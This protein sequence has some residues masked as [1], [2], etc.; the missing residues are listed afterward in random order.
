[1][2]PRPLYFTTL[3]V[4]RNLHFFMFRM[5]F[6]K[7]TVLCTIM[8]FGSVINNILVH[9]PVEQIIN[10][11]LIMVTELKYNILKVSNQKS[12]ITNFLFEQFRQ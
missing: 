5:Y 7:K 10:I 6:L 1:M 9:N 8:Q 12:T 4:F 3:C 2:V 11:R